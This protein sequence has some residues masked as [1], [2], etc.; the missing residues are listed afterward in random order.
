MW[1]KRP[2]ALLV[3]QGTRGETVLLTTA[4]LRRG[5]VGPGWQHSQDQLSGYCVGCDQALR[6][7][8]QLKGIL[9]TGD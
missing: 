6:A 2:P 1:M 7:I 8:Q 3:S 9:K 5:D 4:S